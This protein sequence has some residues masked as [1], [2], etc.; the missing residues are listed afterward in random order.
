MEKATE[1]ANEIKQNGGKAEPFRA[2]VAKPEDS[3]AAVE[4]AKETF[5]GLH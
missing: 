5:S 2:D 1:F 4:F 3:K